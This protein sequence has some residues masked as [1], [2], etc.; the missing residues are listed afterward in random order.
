VREEL[1]RAVE[2]AELDE[3]F[4]EPAAGAEGDR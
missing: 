3:L 2:V 1:G 4:E